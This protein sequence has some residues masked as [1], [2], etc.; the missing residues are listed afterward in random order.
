MECQLLL[1]PAQLDPP[2]ETRPVRLPPIQPFVPEPGIEPEPPLR[3][4]LLL[5]RP[6]GG[7]RAVLVIVV[8]PHNSDAEEVGC[9]T[10]SDQLLVFD[11][12]LEIVLWFK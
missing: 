12:S 10:P 8:A 4:L 6:G 1:F 2:P 7:P 9:G 3:P 5:P 11:P